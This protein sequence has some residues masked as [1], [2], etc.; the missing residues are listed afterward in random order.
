MHCAAATAAGTGMLG[1][2]GC[3][4]TCH[5][6]HCQCWVE[7]QKHLVACVVQ[8][9]DFLRPHLLPCC[10]CKYFRV[11]KPAWCTDKH[12]KRNEL[13][14]IL[15]KL[16]SFLEFGPLLLLVLTSMN[17]QTLLHR[18]QHNGLNHLFYTD[19]FTAFIFG[20]KKSAGIGPEFGYWDLY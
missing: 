9:F 4:C 20:R 13:K 3:V 15:L 16:E 6:M 8:A 11:L 2:D 12:R 18:L 5:S 7:L 10:F 14:F 19:R 17:S 1:R